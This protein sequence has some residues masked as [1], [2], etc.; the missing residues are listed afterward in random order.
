[1]EQDKWSCLLCGTLSTENE[2]IKTS[3]KKFLGSNLDVVFVLRNVLEVPRIQLESQLKKC[4]GDNPENWIRLCETCSQLTRTGRK[5]NEEI[6][7]L[8]NQLEKVKK[9]AT[10]LIKNS[11]GSCKKEGEKYTRFQE[12]IRSFVEN[13]KF[14][15]INN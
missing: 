15:E 10:Q 5:L 1:M 3:A 12:K 8:E 9:Q 4:G 2:E 6:S 14:L 13:S 11:T 7:K